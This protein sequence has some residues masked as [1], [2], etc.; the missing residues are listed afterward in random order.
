MKCTPQFM[1]R[2]EY[3]CL[4]AIQLLFFVSAVKYYPQTELVYVSVAWFFVC[5]GVT[6]IMQPFIRQTY[7][8]YLWEMLTTKN[9]PNALPPLYRHNV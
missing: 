2:T 3:A 4:L 8:V 1:L 5:V 6:C 7:G 9:P